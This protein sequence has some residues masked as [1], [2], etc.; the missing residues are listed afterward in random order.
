MPNVLYYDCENF[1]NIA[2][3]WGKYEQNAIAFLRE[4]LICSIA[5][6]WQGEKKTQCL[7]LPDFPG[8][9]HRTP[10]S[11]KLVK[12]FHSVISKADVS[13]AHNGDRFDD[14]MLNAEFLKHGLT[15]PP[16][17]KTIDTL[18]IARKHFSLNSNRLDDLGQLLGVGSK[19]KHQGFDLWVGCMAGD[20]KAWKLMRKYNGEDVR[21]LERCYLK[22]RP[23]AHSHPDLSN[24]ERNWN[25]PKCESPKL[26]EQGWRYNSSSKRRRYQCKAC[27][28]WSL[29]PSI[30][31]PKR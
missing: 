24:Y 15:P 29:G 3:T 1:P 9:Y 23:W 6:K 17:R 11:R 21:L 22:L 5:W 19:V 25:C 18:K 12:R 14:R 2:Y 8:Y 10:N 27:K 26:T 30:W 7:M 13:I 31:S 16:P 20:M 4:R 28:G